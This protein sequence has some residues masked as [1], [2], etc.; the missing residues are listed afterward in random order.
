MCDIENKAKQLMEELS[1]YLNDR[2]DDP[3]NSLFHYTTFSGLTGILQSRQLWLTDHKYLNDPSE[4]QHGKNIIVKLI[5]ESIKNN[6]NLSRFINDK[7]TDLIENKYKA[8]ITAFCEEGDYLPA[9]RYYGDNGAGFSI[10][11]NNKYFSRNTDMKKRDVTLLF[12]VEYENTNF[13][14]FREIFDIANRIFPDWHINDS[15]V[16]T[17]YISA[18][19]SNLITILPRVKN[20]DYKDEKEWRLCMV[21]LFLEWDPPELPMERFIISKIDHSRI[22]LFAKDIKTSIPR[23]QSLKFGYCDI[24]TIYVGPRLEF[25][26]AKLAIEKILLDSGISE[27]E[28]KNISIK[29]SERP[30]Q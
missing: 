18:L 25:L 19:T 16:L 8:Y 5:N 2:D 26:T 12:K 17:P 15:S 1:K 24:D 4:I 30:Y 13:D 22:P 11:F 6:L 3:N 29:R 14:Q 9:W 28:Y 21:K 23:F 20:E 10:G 27:S 7:I